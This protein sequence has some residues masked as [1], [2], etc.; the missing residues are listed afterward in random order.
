MRQES[1]SV[2]GEQFSSERTSR[3]G[4]ESTIFVKR[5][6][7]SL[8]NQHFL[9]ISFL[10]SPFM[11]FRDFRIS[12]T[13]LRSRMISECSAGAFVNTCKRVLY[14]HFILS[15]NKM[16]STKPSFNACNPLTESSNLRGN[17]TPKTP[18]CWSER[19]YIP[20]KCLY[21]LA[22]TEFHPT[23]LESQSIIVSETYNTY[24][25]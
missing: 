21:L 5:T 6:V 18:R 3:S 2:I 11:W 16:N 15:M 7:L 9:R 10:R 17:Y 1:A 24:Y 22:T 19:Q 12:A 23:R 25:S 20:S 4:Y 8:P 14:Q 13:S